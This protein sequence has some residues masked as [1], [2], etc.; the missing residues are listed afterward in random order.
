MGVVRGGKEKLL[1][2]SGVLVLSLTLIAS[3]PVDRMIKQYAEDLKVRLLHQ[4]EDSFGVD[5]SYRSI[6][7]SFLRSLEVRGFT[8]R[9][10]KDPSSFARISSLKIRYRLFTLLSGNIGEGIEEIILED[11][12]I[13]TNENTF[14]RFKESFT[15][16]GGSSFVSTGEGIGKVPRVVGKG[17]LVKFTSSFGTVTGRDIF[18]SLTQEGGTKVLQLISTIS[19]QGR[20][21]EL[22]LNRFETRVE[23]TS[24]FKNLT[25]FTESTVVLERIETDTF[26]LSRQA[27]RVST[28][29]TKV[30]IKRLEDRTPIDLSVSYDVKEK[31]ISASFLCETFSPESLIQPRKP[32][33]FLFWLNATVSGKGELFYRIDTGNLSYRGSLHGILPKGIL[34]TS[35]YLRVHFNGNLQEVLFSDLYLNNR[36]G[37]ISF[38]G[39]LPFPDLFPEGNLTLENFTYLTPYPI[40]GSGNITRIDKG[41]EITGSFLSWGKAGFHQYGIALYLSEGSKFDVRRVEASFSLTPGSKPIHVYAILPEGDRGQVL[42][43]ITLQDI[44]LRITVP[45]LE[46]AGGEDILKTLEDIPPLLISAWSFFQVSGEGFKIDIPT[47]TLQEEGKEQHV[48]QGSL[49]YNPDG[50]FHVPHLG[51]QWNEQRGLAS[52]RGKRLDRWVLEFDTDLEMFE[53]VYRFSTLL[54][55]AGYMRITSSHQVQLELYGGRGLGYFGSLSVEKLPLEFPPLQDT[56]VSGSLEF[57]YSSNLSWVVDLRNVQLSLSSHWVGR[58]IDI[59]L[60]GT[61]LPGQGTLTSLAI[62]DTFTS[63]EGSGVFEFSLEAPRG[64]LRT[65]LYSKAGQEQYSFQGTY[66]GGALSVDLEFF[67]VPLARLFP[68]GKIEGIVEGRIHGKDILRS[69]EV[70]ADLRI[71][72]GRYARSTFDGRFSFT[73]SETLLDAHRIELTYNEVLSLE[74]KAKADLRKGELEWVTEAWVSLF[75]KP[76][77]GRS[78]G[79]V[80]FDATGSFKDLP[81]LLLHLREGES[82]FTILDASVPDEYREWNIQLVK[83]GTQF[84]FSGGPDH[85]IMG[86]IDTTGL[87]ALQATSPLPISFEASG[88]FLG[89]G[90]LRATF[91]NILFL[92]PTFKQYLDFGEFRIDEGVVRGTVSVEGFLQDPSFSGELIVESGKARLA[93][94]PEDL[95]PFR[96][97]LTFKEKTITLNPITLTTRGGTVQVGGSF[98]LEGFELANTSI[99]VDTGPTGGVR[100]DANFNGVLVDGIGKGRVVIEVQDQE[101]RI[102]GKIMASN[103]KIT[104]GEPPS[105]QPSSPVQDTRL[106]V[107]LLIESGKLVEFVWPTE[108]FPIIRTYAALGQQ[109]QIQADTQTGYFLVRGNIGI[110][111]GQ[112]YYFDRIFYLREGKIIFNER[113]DQFDPII[114]AR[115]EIR[116][117]TQRG[118][119]RIYLVA[120]N[121]RLSQFSPRFESDPSLSPL[122]IFTLLGEG[123]LLTLGTQEAVN[124]STA[125]LLTGDLFLQSEIIR[126]FERDMRNRFNLDLFS[127]RTQIFQNVLSEALQPQGSIPLYQTVPSIGR[128]LDKSSVFLGKYLGSDLFLEYLIQLRAEDPLTS[129]VRKFGGIGIESEV[130]FEWKTPFFTLEWSLRPSN[131]EELFIRDN[132]LSFR[133]RY[134]Y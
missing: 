110:R 65:I 117:N 90:K 45:L 27:F 62:N 116:E 123:N 50:T 40:D 1:F 77:Q 114:S 33:P 85:A 51:F 115:G 105:E 56:L 106:S 120:D 21:E 134:S 48:V 44:P 37:K 89:E 18:F 91:R 69:L 59:T 84:L 22:S 6:S 54:D 80:I 132:T 10:R 12:Y 23:L 32:S 86:R 14:T 107:D 58:P 131:P 52:I 78:I 113:G 92:L 28:E 96:G 94:V 124:L 17:M 49:R 25:E 127:I 103:T 79:K 4:L 9:D 98:E 122:E 19:Y 8:I 129:N 130:V 111:G 67:H 101:I 97:R 2:I 125:L 112:V 3:F 64:K 60:T 30:S 133:W 46:Q 71:E 43:G 128:Y 7:P 81:S 26:I 109:L 13:E 87:F 53:K 57:F 35:T 95:G 75:N 5:L 108:N 24:R 38:Q 20:I 100:I 47:F 31:R 41:V 72:G 93:I 70:S 99:W 63:L 76:L 82:S 88:S 104:L 68:Q 102:N 126:S 11:A 34:Q 118:L 74:G 83:E 15:G 73:L 61:I 66:E 119:V 29:G 16:R 36:Y 55:P 121:T 39:R 42:G